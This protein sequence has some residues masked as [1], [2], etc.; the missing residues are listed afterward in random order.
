MPVSAGYVDAVIVEQIAKSRAMVRLMPYPFKIRALEELADRCKSVLFDNIEVLE[1]LHADLQRGRDAQS[2]MHRVGMCAAH[3][4]AI[5]EHGLPPLQYRTREAAVINDVLRGLHHEMALPIPCPTACCI[6]NQH[7]ISNFP[8]R[9]IYAPIGEALS[10]RHHAHLYHELGHYLLRARSDPRLKPL[11][12]GI[13][14]SSQA[15]EVH[16]DNLMQGSDHKRV[17]PSVVDY[18]TWLRKRW[19]NWLEGCFCDLFGVLG[20]GPA[21][22]WA[23]LHMAAK[24]LLPAYTLNAFGKQSHPP[25]DARMEIMYE[26]LRLMGFGRDAGPVWSRWGDVADT[27]GGSPGSMYRN[28]VPKGILLDV[29]RIM[30][31]SLGE[32]GIVLY[33]PGSQGREDSMRALLNDAWDVFW[34]LRPGEYQRWEAAKIGKIGGPA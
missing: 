13:E 22:A 26:G 29:A 1:S 30:H 17:P 18:V 4:T 27:V 19:P 23:Y 24:R 2:V 31:E 14:R 16:H 7:Y 20:G 3:I 15:I 21:G 28:A 8:T 33:D 11:S 25:N 9:T 12:S 34:R 10:I 32:T 6:S 5:E